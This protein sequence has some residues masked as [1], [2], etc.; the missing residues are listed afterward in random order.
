[1]RKGITMRFTK[2][3]C[4]VLLITFSVGRGCRA[5]IL[6]RHNFVFD[7]NQKMN[8]SEKTARKSMCFLF[9]FFCKKKRLRG[10]T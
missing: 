9:L 10:V 6:K 2:S 3:G 5:L 1:M 4:L 8:D 7:V